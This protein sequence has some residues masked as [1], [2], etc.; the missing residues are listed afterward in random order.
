MYPSALF[1]ITASRS[2][3]ILEVSCPQQMRSLQVGHQ[4][5]MWWRNP[6][7]TLGN[8]ETICHCASAS[9]SISLGVVFKSCALGASKDAQNS[10]K[11]FVI[12]HLLIQEAFPK[13]NLLKANLCLIITCNKKLCFLPGGGMLSEEHAARRKVSQSIIIWEVKNSGCD[14]RHQFTQTGVA[15]HIREA[16]QCLWSLL[17]TISCKI[18]KQGGAETSDLK[19]CFLRRWKVNKVRGV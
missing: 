16:G 12:V 13:P 15:V 17:E 1:P 2:V 5:T 19:S 9:W 14:S 18:T 3:Y 7:E 8:E 11:P 10:H 4:A 6:G